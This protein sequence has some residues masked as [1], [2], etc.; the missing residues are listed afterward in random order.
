M[1]KLFGITTETGS[2]QIPKLEYYWNHLTS[3][4]AILKFREI[5]TA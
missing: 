3:A 5:F 2:V 1:L 4:M